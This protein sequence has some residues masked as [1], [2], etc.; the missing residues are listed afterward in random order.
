MKK[1]KIAAGKEP[2]NQLRVG[3]LAAIGFNQKKN[4]NFDENKKKGNSFMEGM[5]INSMSVKSI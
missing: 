5:Y 4:L 3:N 1:V 2:E